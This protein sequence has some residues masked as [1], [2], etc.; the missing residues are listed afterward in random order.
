LSHGLFYSKS[1]S[2]GFVSFSFFQPILDSHSF[3]GLIDLFFL[4]QGGPDWI[5]ELGRKDGVVSSAAEAEALLPSSH[6]NAA[7]L[8]ASF[9]A[10]G[11]TSRDMVT[12]SGKLWMFTCPNLSKQTQVGT[13]SVLTQ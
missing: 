9:A 2:H 11:L 4:Q 13:Q 7:T 5:V 6:S 3:F 8:V 1:S 12:L 10:L